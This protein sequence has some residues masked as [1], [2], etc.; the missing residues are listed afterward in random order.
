MAPTKRTLR[1]RA[2]T[3][4]VTRIAER[5]L[6]APRSL[7][8]M[9]LLL[10]LLVGAVYV[11]GEVV[12]GAGLGF[13]LDDPWIHAQFARNLAHG[14]GF[15]L[16][17]GEPV[18]GSTS[19]LWTL[20]LTLIQLLPVSAT[21]VIL[22][23]KG[24]GALLLGLSGYL[25]AHRLRCWGAPPAASLLAGIILVLLAPLG[26]GATS[27]LEVGLYVALS[28]GALCVGGD[29]GTPR[30]VIWTG[31]L[32]ALAVWAR[33]ECLAL[34]ALYL[35]DRAL[36]TRDRAGWLRLA[37][38][39]GLFLAALLPYAI[40]NYTLSGLLVPHTFRV[41]VAGE[42]LL[43]AIGA[44]DVAA[45]A[46]LLMSSGPAYVGDLIGHLHLANP[47]LPGGLFVGL[48]LVAPKLYRGASPT[49][50]PFLAVVGYAY[51]LGVV[52][53]FRGAAFQEGRYIANLTA[54][55]ALLSVWG[56]AAGIAWLRR[57]WRTGA[58]AAATV[59]LL[60]GLFN[61]AVAGYAGV[62]NSANSVASINGVQVTLGRWLA[63]H[64]PPRATVATNDIGAIAYF[65]GRRIIDLAGLANPEVVP[66]LRTHGTLDSAA[67][68][69]LRRIRPDYL[70][71]FPRWFPTL[72]MSTPHEFN[73]RVDFLPNTASEWTFFPRART[74]A[75]LLLLD[76][77]IPPNP[78]TMIVLRPDWDA[79]PV[80]LPDTHR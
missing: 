32:F 78:T 65:S 7:A 64:T 73:T 59:L 18:A 19:P 34:F 14:Q 10:G 5:L 31:L 67:R 6:A 16:N 52:A 3:D 35:C 25:G 51:L 30:R 17:A 20:L 4:P 27:G 56:W 42:G 53:P 40:A 57:R 63:E 46:R 58:G 2:G 55:G 47:L 38:V 68:V 48:L 60:A 29:L 8:G 12:R 9:F 15:G 49:L 50:F 45:V 26:W 71:I 13:P 11:L 43:G 44:G 79:P 54:L 23:A 61:T 72:I 66:Y 33:P 74:L 37:G 69:Y 39:T 24:L 77:V 1:P 62:R 36:F 28:L 76:V 70:A 75:G 80:A 21:T 41:K 22:W